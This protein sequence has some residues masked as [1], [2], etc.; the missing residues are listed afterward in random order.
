MPPTPEPADAVEPPESIGPDLLPRGLVVLLTLAAGFIVIAG[1]RAAS[2]I[3]GPVF[4]ALMLTIAVHPLRDIV[5]RWGWPK[6]AGSLV[7]LAAVY[8]ILFGLGLAMVISLARFASL[9]PQYQDQFNNLVSGVESELKNL[10]VSQEQINSVV[11][12]FNIGRLA[13]VLSDLLGSLFS[14]TSNLIFIVILLLFMGLDAGFF[15][16]RLRGMPT[17]RTPLL[18]ALMGFVSGTRTYLVV[19]TIFGFIVAVLDTAALAMLG[20]PVPVL[21]G[22]LAFITNYIPNI[23]FIIGLVPPALLALLEGGWGL[24]LAVIAVYCVINFILQ[25]VLQPRYVGE[26]VGLSATVTMLSL[27]FWAWVLGPL[28]ALLAV[29]MSLLAKAL[30]IDADEDNRWVASL[31]GSPSGS[32]K[33]RKRRR[34]RKKGE[35]AADD[36][37]ADETGDPAAGEPEPSPSG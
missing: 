25:S 27:V 10:G 8:L 15:P 3:I 31:I 30:L 9:L 28:G 11:G 20:V 29:P 13:G 12:N 17:E 7:G 2:G 36:A 4:L 6:W 5:S 16:D 35:P 18:T 24:M 21:W 22:L 34:G 23:G 19:S 37:A 1:M 14:A 33:A 26:S 32:G